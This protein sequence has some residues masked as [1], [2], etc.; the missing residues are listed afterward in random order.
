MLQFP[1]TSFHI[2]ESLQDSSLSIVIINC[3]RG[4][5]CSGRAM[6]GPKGALAPPKFLNKNE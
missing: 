1:S 2:L 6:L 4:Y 3:Q 5:I